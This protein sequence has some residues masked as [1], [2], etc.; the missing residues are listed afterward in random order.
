MPEHTTLLKQVLIEEFQQLYQH[1][2]NDDIYACAL[3]F[4]EYLQIDYLAISTQRSIYAEHE[5]RAQYLSELESITTT[6]SPV[7]SSPISFA[8]SYPIADRRAR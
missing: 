1:Y 2:K 6:V 4:N 3:V 7:F 8:A 5:D